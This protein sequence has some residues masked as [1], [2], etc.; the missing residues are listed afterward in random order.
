MRSQLI[1]NE[2]LVLQAGVERWQENPNNGLPPGA[3]TNVLKAM[4][5]MLGDSSLFSSDYLDTT[6]DALESQIKTIE[7]T[8]DTLLQDAEATADQKSDRSSSCIG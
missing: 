5:Q 1:E 6:Q 8:L 4:N 3:C 2:F 7:T